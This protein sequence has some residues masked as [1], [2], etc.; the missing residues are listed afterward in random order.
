MLIGK[1]IPGVLHI[2][3]DVFREQGITKAL[4]SITSTNEIEKASTG[5]NDG[6]KIFKRELEAASI[7]QS[8]SIGVNVL[9]QGSHEIFQLGD[10]RE[11]SS[12]W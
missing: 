8:F 3:Y 11:Q 10:P 2:T 12:Q 7:Y 5:K 1:G 6:Y 9:R 4:K